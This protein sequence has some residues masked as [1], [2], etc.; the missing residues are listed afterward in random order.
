MTVSANFYPQENFSPLFSLGALFGFR[1]DTQPTWR[2]EAPSL[3]HYV[4]PLDTCTYM[5][6]ASPHHFS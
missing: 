5:Q 3:Q 6:S 2:Y 4:E 1:K